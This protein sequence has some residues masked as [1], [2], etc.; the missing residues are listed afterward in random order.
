[1]G[2]L[3]RNT[4]RKDETVT[5]SQAILQ[6]LGSDSGLFVPDEIPAMDVPLTELAKM[7]YRGLAYEVMSR[8]LTD[9][10]EEELRYCINSAY[11]SKFDDAK[12]APLVKHHGTH[13]L[14]LFHGKTIAFKDMALSILPYL[15]TTA[16]KKNNLKEEI[17]I[18]TAT[19]GDT[20]KA[21][22]AGFADAY[23]ELK[24]D[25]VVVLGDRYEILA[26]AEAAMIERIP[27]AHIHGGEVTEG[28][29]D[30]AIRHSITKMSQL[31]FASTEEY[32]HRIIQLGEQPER[33]FNTGAIG[34][35]NVK[36]LSLLS[37]D[38]IEREI[39]FKIDDNTILVTYHPVTLGKRTA[40][41]DIEDFV[42]ALEERKDIRIIFT[43]P[44]S[45]TGSQF[46][47]D[48]I[49]RFV[50]RN[51]IRSKA[52]KSLGVVRYL[53]VMRQVAAV[54]GNSSS[55]IVEVPSFGIPTLNIGD[56][57]KG[58]IAGESVYN[59]APDKESILNGLNIIFSNSF[60]ELASVVRN[61]YEKANTAEE[62]FK[63]ISTYPLE[64]LNQKHFYDIL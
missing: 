48:A 27:I 16:A 53:S 13:F 9:F 50:E 26:A 30:D 7:D 41:D 52:Y 59:C 46:I 31:H 6:G 21:A 28:A 34:V 20:G 25:M 10:T 5:A 44:N 56:R 8:M 11:D 37:K 38:E 1:M 39:D 33:V 47:V 32:R 62:I 64:Q 29:F 2:F 35:E 51:P 15:M 63:V 22:L 18:L 14:E 42:S 36:K 55:G 17:V 58:R 45:D 60:K 49:N 19:S 23:N 24:P 4:R 40:K 54:V 12:I 43:M 57:Q 3:Y 61:P